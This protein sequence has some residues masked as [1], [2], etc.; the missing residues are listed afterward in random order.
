MF[1]PVAGKLML[2]TTVVNVELV[3]HSTVE[4]AGISMPLLFLIV[5]KETNTPP[6]NAPNPLLAFQ[7]G[8]ELRITAAGSVSV[9]ETPLTL[10]LTTVTF[11]TLPVGLEAFSA[12]KPRLSI[13]DCKL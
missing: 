4:E 13:K 7:T 10:A 5:W 9:S 11:E 6:L 12:P 3:L 8:G 2:P 1:P